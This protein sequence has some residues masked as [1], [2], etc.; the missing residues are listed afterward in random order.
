M[1]KFD[2][3]DTLLIA[4]AMLFVMG[5]ALVGAAIGGLIIGVAIKTAMLV[6]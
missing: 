6:L 3:N 5:M 2:W 1:K 4:G